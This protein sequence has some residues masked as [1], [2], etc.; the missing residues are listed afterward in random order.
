MLTVLLFLLVVGGLIALA[1]SRRA[2]RALGAGASSPGAG[3]GAA[4][5]D[6]EAEARRW[7]D[8]LGGQVLSLTGS[9]DPSRQ[10]LAD[11]SE[12]YTA[13]GSQLSSATTP[14]QYRLVTDTALE[15]LHFVRAARTAMGMDPGPELPSSTDRARAGELTGDRS[16]D[17]EGRTVTGSPSTSTQ[18]SHYYPGGNVA[19]RP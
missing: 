15:G 7:Y 4:D 16:V 14:G 9:D 2:P 6:A 19:G 11:A 3:S 5:V 17:V 12:R 8:R 13:A 10:A 1:V 18:N